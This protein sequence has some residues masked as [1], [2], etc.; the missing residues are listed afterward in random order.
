MKNAPT[1]SARRT[2]ATEVRKV[3]SAGWYP[4]P[5]DG[6]RVASVI[7]GPT[8]HQQTEPHAAD[9]TALELANDPPLVDDQDPIAQ[10][11][12]FVEIERDE[13]HAASLVPLAHQLGVDEL[14]GADI[15]P[16]RRL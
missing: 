9:L 16:A 2:A 10:I 6:D 13:E 14:D 5:L 1:R 3:V 4:R 11:E 15:E 7:R 12:D 8:S